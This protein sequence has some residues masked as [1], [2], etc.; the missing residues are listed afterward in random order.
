MRPWRAIVVCAALLSLAL[1]IQVSFLARLGLPGSTPDLVLVVVAGIALTYGATTGA[2]AGFA[3][4]LLV[5]LA[6]PAD[7]AVGQWALVLTLAGYAAGLAGE[8]TAP[9]VLVRPATVLGIGALTAAATLAALSVGILVDGW[10]PGVADAATLIG[11]AAAYGAVLSLV[12]VPLVRA[13]LRWAARQTAR[14]RSASS[15][16]W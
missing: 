2:V 6:P 12:V 8:R 16:P 10:W 3:G 1:A 13:P 9:P 5:D 4:G 11:S 15:Q 7:H 14:P